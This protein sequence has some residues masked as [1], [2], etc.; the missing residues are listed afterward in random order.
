MYMKLKYCL[1]NGYRLFYPTM[2]MF[3]QNSKKNSHL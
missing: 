3:A 2:Y 1:T